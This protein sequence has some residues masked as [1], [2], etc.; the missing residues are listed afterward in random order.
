MIN[1]IFSN[2]KGHNIFVSIIWFDDFNPAQPRKDDTKTFGPPGNLAI[3]YSWLKIEFVSLLFNLST[4]IDL[5]TVLRRLLGKYHEESHPILSSKPKL[6]ALTNNSGPPGNLAI[7]YSWL[8]EDYFLVIG[9]FVFT[10]ST[11]IDSKTGLLKYCGD[12]LRE[13]IMNITPKIKLE[14][15]S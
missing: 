3:R 4:F 1:H 8:I 14:D 10:S 2:W 6:K 13:N 15:E 11:S 5:K 7:I 9:I 12:F